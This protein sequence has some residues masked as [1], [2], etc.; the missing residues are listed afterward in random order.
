MCVGGG[1]GELIFGGAYFRGG[2]IIGILWYIEI[3][4]SIRK[5]IEVHRSI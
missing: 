4:R 5:H 3:Y 1:G 2:L